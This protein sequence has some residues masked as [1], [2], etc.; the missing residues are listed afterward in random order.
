MTDL[1]SVT[2]ETIQ[3]QIY[4]IRGKQ[5]MMDRD[6]AVLYGVE[7]RV[8]NQAVKRNIER[9]P[10]E[11]FI[12]RLDNSEFKD[13]RSQIVISNSDKQG[14]RH[15]PFCFTEVGIVMLSAV[16]RSTTA[17]NVSIKITHAFVQMRRFLGE[18][19][20][21]FVRLDNVERKQLKADEN[22]EKLFTALESNDLKPKQGIF[23]DGQV[24]D[25]YTFVADLVRE[26]KQSIVLIDNYID[27]TI[28][29]LFVKRQNGVSLTIYTQKIS[30]QLALD[31]QK[32]NAQYDPVIIKQF[33]QAHDRFLIVDE[34]TVYHI[35]ASLKDLGKKWFAFSKIDLNVTEMLAKLT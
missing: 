17:V 19:A 4:T 2:P 21:V 33:G 11:N 32:H 22:F 15:I 31:L 8:L 10:D 34:T 30:S 20:D 26:A 5:V 7:T 12:F 13:W 18:N 27:D 9:F 28:L 14:L 25:A 3:N 35:G 24:F 23:Y 1:I 16:L 29:R 6:L